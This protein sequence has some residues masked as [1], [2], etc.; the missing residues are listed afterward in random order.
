MS[1]KAIHSVEMFVGVY[2]K[3]LSGQAST[4]PGLQVPYE[5]PESP[6]VVVDTEQQTSEEGVRRIMDRL[7]E[8]SFLRNETIEDR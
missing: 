7:G 1:K 5:P 8:L 6:A 3:G 2:E 4:I